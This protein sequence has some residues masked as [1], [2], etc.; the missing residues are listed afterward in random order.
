MKKILVIALL[1]TLK[2][3]YSLTL[4]DAFH[5]ALNNYPDISIKQ[6]E[7][8]ISEM[9]I[10]RS[11][12]DFLPKLT[13][14]SS[15]SISDPD[16]TEKSK[17][18]N[19]EIKLTYNLFSGYSTKSTIEI[20]KYNLMIS[21]NTKTLTEN[22]IRKNVASA[23]FDAVTNKKLMEHYG[24]LLE[25][26]KKVYDF[27]KTKFEVG[28]A[29][30]IDVMKALTD[31]KKYEAKLQ[32][33]KNSYLNSLVNLGLYTDEKYTI[34]TILET[35]FPII[36]LDDDLAFFIKKGEENNIDINT[37]NYRI[38][39]AKEDIKKNQSTLFPSLDIYGSYSNSNI[40][41]GSINNTINTTSIGI[42]LTWNIFNGKKDILNV[43][44]QKLSYYNTIDEKRKALLNLKKDISTLFNNIVSSKK[45]LTYL[46]DLVSVT[47]ENYKLTQEAYELGRA[48]LIELLRSQDELTS[49]K[50]D[51]INTYN[52][53]LQN[54][55]TLKYLIG[56]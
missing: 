38:K 28:R 37:F 52:S 8:E 18:F 31:V 21:Q 19:N 34:D 20:S 43:E 49:A 33:Q 40:D 17:V 7:L 55:L 22:F 44:K 23:Y 39:S 25:N 11:K 6:R 5:K 4:E 29:L 54:F 53:L 15:Y 41:K 45:N 46:E 47:T 27:T 51:Y 3:G 10:K 56:E 36:N 12:G 13:F 9:E 26:A 2:N 35:D 30:S 32:Q 14:T 48:S 50:L 1:L 42:S 24:K 16:N